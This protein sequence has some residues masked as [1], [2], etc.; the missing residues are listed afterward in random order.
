RGQ[1]WGSRLLTVFWFGSCLEMTVAAPCAV[2]EN[3]RDV[4]G[5]APAEGDA[6]SSVSVIVYDTDA[7]DF[8]SALFQPDLRPRVATA[9]SPPGMRPRRGGVRLP[10]GGRPRATR[11]PVR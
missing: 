10:P 5:A 6:G 8:G 4:F 9:G 2:K 11:G 7:S 3:L 1:E